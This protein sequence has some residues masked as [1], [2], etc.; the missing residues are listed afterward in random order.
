MHV[1]RFSGGQGGGGG[2]GGTVWWRTPSNQPLRPQRDAP[3]FTATQSDRSRTPF[4]QTCGD[5][6][7]RRR[8]PKQT[9]QKGAEQEY[10]SAQRHCSL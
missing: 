7:C 2:G 8:S 10:T 6:G 5:E 1:Q 4:T 9:P 3:I